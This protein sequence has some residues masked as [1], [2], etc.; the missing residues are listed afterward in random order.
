M[1][2]HTTL[3][4]VPFTLAKTSVNAARKQVMKDEKIP[5]SQQP[6]SQFQNESGGE[7]T[8]G[9]SKPGGGNEIES[10]QQ[11]TM[12]RSHPGQGRWGAGKVKSDPV[13]G[14]VRTNEYGRPVLENDKSKVDYV[15]KK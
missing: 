3:G 9:V 2:C 14:E 7:Y 6:K 10:V 11:Q 1:L 13:T 4:W 15:Q 8:Y 5:T 12:N